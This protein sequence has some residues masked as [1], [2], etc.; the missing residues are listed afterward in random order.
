VYAVSEKRVVAVSPPGK[1][2]S[3]GWIQLASIRGRA[4]ELGIV[5]SLNSPWTSPTRR[6]ERGLLQRCIA[7]RIPRSGRVATHQPNARRLLSMP[8]FGDAY[9]D[10]EMTH[11]EFLRPLAVISR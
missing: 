4:G 3:Q 11:Y 2:G 9:S 10:D 1:R 7:I 8:A 5:G 6:I